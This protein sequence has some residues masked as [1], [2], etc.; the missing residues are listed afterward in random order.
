MA[1]VMAKM[2]GL[3][4][5]WMFWISCWEFD[6]FWNHFNVVNSDD[7]ASEMS[8]EFISEQKLMS[9]KKLKKKETLWKRTE[10]H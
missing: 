4:A 5:Q 6:Q 2:T 10:M 9:S 7:H 1:Q 3:I 8:T